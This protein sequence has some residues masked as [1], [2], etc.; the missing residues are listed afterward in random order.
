MFF[1]KTK[2]KALSLAA[3]LNLTVKSVFGKL[4]FENLIFTPKL[5]A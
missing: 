4:A 1:D 2:H 5:L 3:N